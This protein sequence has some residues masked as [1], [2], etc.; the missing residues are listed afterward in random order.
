MPERYCVDCGEKWGPDD[1]KCPDCGST[2]YSD[3]PEDGEDFDEEDV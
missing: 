3:I 2:D 1:E